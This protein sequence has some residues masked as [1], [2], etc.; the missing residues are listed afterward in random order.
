MSARVGRKGF[1]LR[2]ARGGWLFL[3]WR[4]LLPFLLLPPLVGAVLWLSWDRQGEFAA[5]NQVTIRDLLGVGGERPDAL[6]TV[7]LELPERSLE[8]ILAAVRRGDPKRGRDPG[9]TKPYVPGRYRDE[10]GTWRRCKVALRGSTDYHWSPEKPS[11]RVKLKKAEASRGRRFVELQRPEDV[12]ALGNLL[13]EELARELGVLSNLSDH[14]RLVVNGRYRGVYVRT[15]RPG[16]TLATEQGRLPG[17]FFKGDTFLPQQ[18][19]EL[20]RDVNTWRAADATPRA[21]HALQATLQALARGGER[22]SAATIASLHSHIDTDAFARWSAAMA[23]AGGARTDYAHNHVLFWNTYRGLF[24]PAVWDVNGYGIATRPLIP[25]DLVLQPFQDRLSRDPRWVHQRNLHLHRLLEGA[26][27]QPAQS[28]RI[29]R[30]LTRLRPA[31]LADP[32]LSTVQAG[33]GRVVRWPASRLEEKVTQLQRW[34]AARVAYLRVYLGLAIVYAEPHPTRPGSVRIQVH[35]TA[36]TRVARKDGTTRLLYPGLSEKLYQGKQ[37]L[38]PIV[39]PYVLP[40]PRWYTLPGP[41]SELRFENALTGAPVRRAEQP[42][43]EVALRTLSEDA[44]PP[45]PSG[46]VVLGPGV[47]T[48]AHDLKLGP[49]QPLTIR[50]GTTLRLGPGVGIY[51]RG[52]VTVAGEP[53]APV[54]LEPASAKPWA[55][56][57]LSGAGTRGSRLRYLFARGGSTGS[58]GVVRF[59]GMVNAYHCPDLELVGCRFAKNVRGDDAVNLAQSRIRVRGCVF[60][61]APADGLDLDRCRGVVSDSTFRRCGNDGLDLMTCTLVVRDSRFESC[62]DKGISVG[63]ATRLVVR[64]VQV[65]ECGVGVEVKDASAARVDE[66]RLERNAIGVRL[67]PKKWTYRLGGF[68]LLRRTRL[69]GSTRA[70]ASVEDRSRLCLLE[71]NGSVLEGERI[72]RLETL[73]TLWATFAQETERDAGAR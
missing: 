12:L 19:D 52:R 27:S 56:L 10:G 55:C 61:D 4:A 29:E 37:Q 21:R 47:V 39:R 2:R 8:L 57:G 43:Q 53:G 24:E 17:A 11:L 16:E 35:G 18:P 48:L 72:T 40:A 63:E 36:A 70:A 30:H 22:P 13:P 50:A 41:L 49:R 71:A 26:G 67:Y 44:F 28:Q 3:P 5:A 42:A 6:P 14:V 23:L 64:G 66:A 25:V 68:L 20:W 38:G 34:I 51:A 58:D 60:E 73:P 45:Q 54:V 69:S 33:L 62:G 7:H 9:G 59:K 32:H 46:P 1:W 15:T 31:L 65:S